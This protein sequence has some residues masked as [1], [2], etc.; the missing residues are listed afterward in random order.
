M[1]IIS[2]AAIGSALGAG[3]TG[4][5]GG[6]GGSLGSLGSILGAVL[7]TAS[8]IGTSLFNYNSSKKI[9]K[10]NYKYAARLAREQRAWQERMANTAHQREVADLRAAGLNPILTATGGSGAPMPAAGDT[11]FTPAVAPQFDFS[12]ALSAY[13]IMRQLDREDR[14]ADSKI[15]VD[16]MN[17]FTA[18]EA[19]DI[20]FIEEIN[21]AIRLTAQHKHETDLQT[22]LQ[23]LRNVHEENQQR[24]RLEHDEKQQDANRAIQK[25]G[26]NIQQNWNE[27]YSDFLSKKNDREWK[28]LDLE[29]QLYRLQKA[30]FKYERGLNTSKEIRSWFKVVHDSV[31]SW[32]PIKHQY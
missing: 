11:G 3:A 28:K 2:G 17:A 20:R 27:F 32:F 9:N 13:S 18:D 25:F 8:Q 26:H 14:L 22:G 1:P 4:A 6:L 12:S 30:R 19:N 21:K 29:K 7:P 5:L 24:K 23:K 15:F 10:Q 16:K 31:R